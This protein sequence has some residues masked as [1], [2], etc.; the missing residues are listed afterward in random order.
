MP[1]NFYTFPEA[2]RLISS[3]TNIEF[4]R[5]DLLQLNEKGLAPIYFEYKGNIGIFHEYSNEVSPWLFPKAVFQIYINGIIKSKS[6][7]QRNITSTTE[8]FGKPQSKINLR[9]HKSKSDIL[10]P[11]K[12]EIIPTEIIHSNPNLNEIP[13]AFNSREFFVGR[14]REGTKH[15][16]DTTTMI[17]DS[18][19]LFKISDLLAIVNSEGENQSIES[20]S[21][22]ITEH[23]SKRLKKREQQILAIIYEAKKAGHD[24][25][26]I[27]DGGKQSLMA[28]C[29]IN[30]PK[31]FGAGNDPFL[32]AWSVAVNSNPPRLR[33]RN[34]SMYASGSR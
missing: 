17:P 15:E 7:C 12:I 23:P 21:N 28:S 6:N 22:Q 11:H 14:V 24:L 32:K 25:L 10:I 29:K 8:N 2:I 34:H 5:N 1:K 16:L 19:W 9:Q 4:S 31:L 13:V 30:Y 3:K 33:M 27:E 20:G 26:K 18:E